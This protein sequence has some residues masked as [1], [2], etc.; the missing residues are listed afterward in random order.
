[1]SSPL[2]GKL[3][4]ESGEGL[5]PSHAVKGNRRY[6]YYVSRRLINGTASQ[7]ETGWRI[8][9]AEIERTVATAVAAT[10]DDRSALL[11]DIVQYDSRT[12]HVKS[13]LDAART[14]SRRLRSREQSS[15]TLR[16]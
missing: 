8:P 6:R 14:C 16:L 5:T 1:M 4:E 15:N 11:N 9:A 12:A 13:N 7:S 10:L 3:F 2:A